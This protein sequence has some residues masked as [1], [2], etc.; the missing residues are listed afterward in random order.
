MKR[1]DD[2][3]AERILTAAYTLDGDGLDRTAASLGCPGW[4]GLVDVLDFPEIGTG[5]GLGALSAA[6]PG[7]GVMEITDGEADLPRS[8]DTFRLSVSVEDEE[9]YGLSVREGIVESRYFRPDET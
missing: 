7:D 9:I 5:G 6:L 4:S 8:V 3:L 1:G 2:R